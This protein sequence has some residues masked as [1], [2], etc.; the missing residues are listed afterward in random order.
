MDSLLTGAA[1][2]LGM[3][4]LPIQENVNSYRVVTFPELVKE[5]K[6]HKG[7]VV[8]VDLWTNG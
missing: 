1:F 8:V 6:N 3:T 4:A 5:L 2:L 7:K